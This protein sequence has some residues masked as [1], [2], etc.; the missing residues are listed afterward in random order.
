MLGTDW[1]IERQA[2]LTAADRDYFRSLLHH[3]RGPLFNYATGDHLTEESLALVLEFQRRLLAAGPPLEQPEWLEGFTRRC[4]QHVPH[5][6]DYGPR[7][8]AELPTLRRETLRDAYWRLVP[9]HLNMEELFIYTTSGTTGTA[10]NIPAD[11]L[12]EACY[13]PL[14]R[15]VLQGLGLTLEGGPQRV[16]ILQVAAQ[17]RTLTYPA[18][19]SVL[20]GAGFVKVNLNPAC[21]RQA[22]D[23]TAFLQECAPEILTGTPIAFLELSRLPVKLKPKALVSTSMGMLP[24]L[25]SF[26]AQRFECPVVDLYSLSE[27]RAVAWRGPG[28]SEYLQVSPD[29][30]IEIFDAL[31]DRPLPPGERGEIVLSGGR[32]RFFP[33]LR[34]RTGDFGQLRRP[35]LY[36]LEGRRPV[37]FRNRA[38]RWFDNI[39]VTHAVAHLPL[40]QYHLHQSATGNLR[41]RYR[42]P[43][44]AEAVRQ[45]LRGLLGRGGRL[46]V[47]D[48]SERALETAKWISFT[49]DLEDPLLRSG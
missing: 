25:Q 15:K 32:N 18:V 8:F 30:H 43:V 5:Y 37:R 35:Y 45:A 6:R 21:W 10:V 49:S 12:S 48:W 39:D 7:S 14:L 1:D 33:L 38:G 40:A 4:Q 2:C 13:V 24:A 17:Q 22:D 20:Q 23:R 41:F 11:A 16:S 26:L 36:G 34:Y 46:Q 3:P 42:G 29:I 44:A 27:C 31:E 28:Q 9:L 19:L 47:Q